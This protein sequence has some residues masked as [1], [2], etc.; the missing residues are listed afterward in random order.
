M[1][2]AGTQRGRS[3]RTAL[4]TPQLPG[5]L[6]HEILDRRLTVARASAHAPLTSPW[7]AGERPYAGTALRVSRF[8]GKSLK[9]GARSFTG[10]RAGRSPHRILRSPT[11][12]DEAGL[13]DEDIVRVFTGDF[14]QEDCSL[15]LP[16]WAGA[17]EAVQA[18]QLV[19]DTLLPRYMRP[20]GIPLTPPDMARQVALPGLHTS[21]SSALLPWNLFIGEGLLRYGYRAQ[22]A[23]LVTRLMDAIIPSLKNPGHSQYYEQKR[24]GRGRTGAPSAWPPGLFLNTL[25]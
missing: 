5:A 7:R 6:V 14:T 20:F 10:R 22:A 8:E 16:L 17:P 13:G 18:K 23:E 2:R 15:F 3:L 12:I 25:D 11:R 4:A 21:L 1:G 24:P 9:P 19:E